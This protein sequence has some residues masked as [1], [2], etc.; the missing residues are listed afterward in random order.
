ML[1]PDENL[2]LAP[3]SPRVPRGRVPF[4]RVPL[5]VHRTLVMGDGRHE[6]SRFA[7]GQHSVSAYCPPRD[8]AALTG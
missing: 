8:S 6:P 2:I 7:D 5:R 3:L 4:L 1:A